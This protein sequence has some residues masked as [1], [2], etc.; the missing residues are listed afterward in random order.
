MNTF[1]SKSDFQAQFMRRLIVAE[2]IVCESL[3]SIQNG[4]KS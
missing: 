3:A 2:T 4:A 1:P